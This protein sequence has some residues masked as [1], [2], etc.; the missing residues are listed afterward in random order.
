M[1]STIDDIRSGRF[2]AP[3]NALGL[4]QFKDIVGFSD[5]SQIEDKY[6]PR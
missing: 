6:R 1:Q 2:G 5:W 4:E 3:Q